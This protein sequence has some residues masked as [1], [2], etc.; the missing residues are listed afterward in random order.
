MSLN[1]SV[2]AGTRVNLATGG[3]IT[4]MSVQ[5]GGEFD[6][7]PSFTH[8]SFQQPGSSVGSGWTA[9][10]E[11][12][13]LTGGGGTVSVRSGAG[14][15]RP[16]SAQNGSGYFLPSPG[17]VNSL[18]TL[19]DGTYVETHGKG[20]YWKVDPQDISGGSAVSH[21]FGGAE[22]EGACELGDTAQDVWEWLSGRRGDWLEDTAYAYVVADFS[23]LLDTW[24]EAECR[25]IV[26]KF[27]DGSVNLSDIFG[28]ARPDSNRKGFTPDAFRKRCQR[29]MEWLFEEPV[30]PRFPQ[31]PDWAPLF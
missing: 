28:G 25:R 26:S 23:D 13:I 1:T 14:T 22:W 20:L 5:K 17:A 16:Y 12:A 4:Q 29:R 10:Y 21:F 24:T 6:S 3:V 2:G 11:K 31:V 30:P 19:L 9:S 15:I 27:A 7:V 18:R 8:N